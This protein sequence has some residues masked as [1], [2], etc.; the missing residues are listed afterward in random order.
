MSPVLPAVQSGPQLSSEH[1]QHT[2]D[3]VTLCLTEGDPSEFD[4]DLIAEAQMNDVSTSLFAV[5]RT[6]VLTK[7]PMTCIDGGRCGGMRPS[8]DPK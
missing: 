3:R 8:Q 6:E 5:M 2:D 1:E 4:L 7:T